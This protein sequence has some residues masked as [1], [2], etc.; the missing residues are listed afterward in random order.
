MK[1]SP[2]KISV[3]LVL[4]L[5]LL[6][7][8]YAYFLT[9][10]ADWG[11]DY[12]MYVAHAKNIAEGKK[13][14]DTGYIPNPTRI[15]C[16]A[17]YPPVFPLLLAPAYKIFGLNFVAFKIVIL[18]SFLLF[19]LFVFKLFQAELN[20]T[21]ALITVLFLGAHPFFFYFITRLVLSD[22]PFLLFAYIFL[23][24]AYQTFKQGKFTP[25]RLIILGFLAYL[26]YGTRTAGL[27]LPL[28]LS[29]EILLKT[30]Q[31]KIPRRKSFKILAYFNLSFLFFFFLEKVLIGNET[32]HWKLLSQM[33]P[34]TLLSNLL[35]YPK[36]FYYYFL[37][38]EEEAS[39]S[40]LSWFKHVV[41][42][43]FLVVA[44]LGFWKRSREKFGMFELFF[45][46]YIT[47]LVLWTGQQGMRFFFPLLP[48]SLM[49]FFY[50]I[51]YF[52]EKIRKKIPYVFFITSF[53]FFAI[54]YYFLFSSQNKIP[55]GPFRPEIKE[56]L[57]FLKKE[58]PDSSVIMTEYT[59][60]VGLFTHKKVMVWDYAWH[61]TTK[62]FWDFTEK[63]NADYLLFHK[64][65]TPFHLWFY[66]N[67]EPLV[68]KD[69]NHWKKIY[70]R[71]NLL[72]YKK[73][74]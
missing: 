34:E 8:F 73:Q 49:Y 3:F 74:K 18:C 54:R 13:Y 35:Y 27:I 6:G 48:L 45:L 26:A 65:A 10:Y 25:F 28:A 40:I 62:E 24:F 9:P 16:P 61:P 38:L 32:L 1:F 37:W 55:D 30:L 22:V 70:D 11:D 69:T 52:S 51:T 4:F 60:T 68:R 29:G 2:Q 57:Q 64:N 39:F 7:S 23:F 5:L 43:G 63:Y 31:K 20:E 66:T 19:L 58:V 14:A 17:F 50:G 67:I 15:I 33:T 46:G 42:I 36:V 21:Y 44:V 47:M 12:A 59:R 71:N 53:L 56:V 72:I 41:R